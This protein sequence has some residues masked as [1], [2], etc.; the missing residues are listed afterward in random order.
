MTKSALTASLLCVLDCCLFKYFL[1]DDDNIRSPRS[2]VTSWPYATNTTTSRLA[3]TRNKSTTTNDRST[4][5][6][7]D[8]IV[9]EDGTPNV[10]FIRTTFPYNQ[11]YGTSHRINR[12]C[13]ENGEA[14][15]SPL[16]FMWSD[17][18]RSMF[19]PSTHRSTLRSKQQTNRPRL[20]ENSRRANP[21][22]FFHL[23]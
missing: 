11:T 1:L 13:S 22:V 4:S 9:R 12:S 15:V 5:I 21:S 17:V 16:I 2:S 7:A 18:G 8:I 3:N 19:S 10:A 6:D 14:R 20:Y 23:I